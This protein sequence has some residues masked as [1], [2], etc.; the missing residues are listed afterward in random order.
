VRPNS[1]CRKGAELTPACICIGEGPLGE[2]TGR[3]PGFGTHPRH[4][5]QVQIPKLWKFAVQ[6]AAEDHDLNDLV[7]VHLVRVVSLGAF[8]NRLEV[9]LCRG[10]ADGSAKAGLCECITS[11]G[12]LAGVRRPTPSTPGTT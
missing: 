8:D 3:G 6:V 10:S 1:A 4:D 2:I 5:R 12:G 7:D 9:S 11:N